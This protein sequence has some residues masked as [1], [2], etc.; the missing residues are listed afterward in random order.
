MEPRECT[1]DPQDCSVLPQKALVT[2]TGRLRAP[3]RDAALFWINWE[4][5]LRPRAYANA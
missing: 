5:P 3:S 1:V 4:L 2:F